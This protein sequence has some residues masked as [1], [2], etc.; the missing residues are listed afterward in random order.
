MII[1][2]LFWISVLLILHTYAFYPLLLTVLDRMIGKQENHKAAGY[3]PFVSVLMVVHNEENVIRKKIDCLL[4]SDY[5]DNMI[6]FIIGSDCC[7]DGTDNI[8]N[9]MKA[10]ASSIKVISFRERMGKPA[11][12]NRL[13][14][15]ARG[16]I[17]LITDA[18]VFPDRHCIRTLV[19]NFADSSIGLTD[20]RLINTGIKKDGIAVP[21]VTYISIESKIKNIEGRLWG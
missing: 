3:T 20:S 16:E 21:E 1:N 13:S 5:P 15:L 4:S 12:I 19:S 10:R 9:E 17:L 11:A 6:E 8:L 2:I 18:N 7:N 14:T